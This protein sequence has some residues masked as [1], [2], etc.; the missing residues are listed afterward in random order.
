MTRPLASPRRANH[1]IGRLTASGV[2]VAA[3][4]LVFV[5]CTTPSASVSTA[6]PTAVA[7]VTV[8]A[9][10][11]ATSSPSAAPSASA[12]PSG[13]L[14]IDEDH[15]IVLTV[16]P[17]WLAIGAGDAEDTAKMDALRAVSAEQAK[18]VDSLV[19]A[20]KKHPEYW[21]AAMR[22]ADQAVI[23]AQLR[24]APDFDVWSSEQKAALE[25]AYGQIDATLLS[26]PRE[27]VMFSWT[28]NGFDQR[29]YGFKRPGSVAL[30]TIGGRAGGSSE[31]WDEALASFT[32][33]GKGDPVANARW[34]L[35]GHS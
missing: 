26:T 14:F 22:R 18:A 35:T 11:D 16:P 13:A 24:E 7:S 27:G 12:A 6:A 32:D 34:R 23:T 25:D 29:L 21:M 20:L 5:G 28:N 9:S 1:P 15:G 31:G 8:S 19:N 4:A 17:E 33:T 30:F 3:L 10:P 2:A